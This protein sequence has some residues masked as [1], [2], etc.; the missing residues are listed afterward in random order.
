M[1]C[2]ETTS[3]SNISRGSHSKLFWI[4][5]SIEFLE[6][7]FRKNITIEREKELKVLSTLKYLDALC[8]YFWATTPVVSSFT[9]FAV[10]YQ[11]GHILTSAKVFTSLAL[12][13]TLL[14]PLNAFPW[15]LNGLGNIL[16]FE[17]RL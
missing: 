10:Y 4:V 8:V 14:V 2:S 9:T 3:L 17:Y 1:K 6:N 15:V 7:S 11:Q 16:D 5:F 13:N 12:F